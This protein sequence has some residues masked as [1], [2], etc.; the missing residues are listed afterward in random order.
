MRSLLLG[1]SLQ[2]LVQVR[3]TL[4][5]GRPP[6]RPSFREAHSHPQSPTTDAGRTA[7]VAKGP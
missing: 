2:Y 6:V 4:G 5:E 7:T 3:C 1:P